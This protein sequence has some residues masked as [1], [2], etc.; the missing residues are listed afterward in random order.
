MQRGMDKRGQRGSLRRLLPWVRP[1]R[2]DV[3]VM[4]ITDVLALAAQMSQP[5][6]IAA[7]IDG[8]ILH[9][10]PVGIWWY[11]AAMLGLG[12][13]QTVMYVLRRRA[14]IASIRLEHD[15]RVA[16]YAQALRWEP[17]LHARTGS[18]HVISRTTGDLHTVGSYFSL[19]LPYLISTVS[20]LIFI[21]VILVVLNPAMD[22]LVLVAMIPMVAVSRAFTHRYESLAVEAGGRT[23][24]LANAASESARGIRMIK[25]RQWVDFCCNYPSEIRPIRCF[26]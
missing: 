13:V 3:V 17:G 18:G 11:G 14:M 6:L 2:R 21:S 20:T 7:M 8:P 4:I 23:D 19:I 9:G 15:L 22:A 26:P 16:C 10:D 5:L 24:R 1:Y 25:L 12:I